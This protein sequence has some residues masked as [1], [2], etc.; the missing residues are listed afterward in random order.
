MLNNVKSDNQ[1]LDLLKSIDYKKSILVIE[2]IDCMTKIIEERSNLKNQKDNNIDNLNLKEDIKMEIKKLKK[3]ISDS[4]TM[5]A[6]PIK[7][8]SDDESKLSL[9]GLLNAIDGIFNSDGRILI[10]T[11]NHPDVLDK[12]LIRPGRIDRKILFNLCS[13]EQIHDMYKMMFGHECDKHDLNEIQDYKYSPAQITSLF[14]MYKKDPSSA[15][16]N[17]DKV[18][19][20]PINLEI[21]LF[22]DDILKIKNNTRDNMQNNFIISPSYND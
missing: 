7:N 14:V 17:I 10:M 8:I 2:D 4:L 19:F 18:E 6:N 11:T 21:K 22:S 13:R 1:L 12:A 3:E 9:S 5:T 20:N 15:L 16:K